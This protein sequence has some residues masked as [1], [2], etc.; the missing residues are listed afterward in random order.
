V[1]AESLLTISA[2][3]RAVDLAPSTLRYYHEAGLLPPAE[4]D[5]STGYRYYTPEL[6][7]R[8]HLIRR[9]REI[10]VSVQSMRLVLEGPADRAADVLAGVAEAARERARQTSAVVD[11]VISALRSEERAATSVAVVV[12]GSE[13]AAGLRRVSTVAATGDEPGLCGVLLDLDRTGLSVVATDRYRLAA[14]EI[15]VV[16]ALTEQ[17]RAFV[18]LGAIPELVEWLAR[19]GSLTIRLGAGQ[20]SLIDE[21]TCRPVETAP[22]RFPAYRLIL[23]SLPTPMGRATFSRDRVMEIL[24]S[25]DEAP[26]RLSVGNDRVTISREGEPEGVHLNAVTS[27]DRFT[28]S[29]SPQLFHGALEC[30]V[31]TEVSVRYVEP[32]QP[33]QLVS[34][35]QRRL[36]LLLM[37]MR[38]E[39]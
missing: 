23:D 8:A 30:M 3:A 36:G 34:V 14:W 12:D 2:F 11:E 26:A 13:L 7:R 25:M 20:A 39:S 37:P 38:A 24:A 17:R 9:M 10:G 6:A 15:P 21:I 18:P 35:E 29:L 4:I 5:A 31:G 28:V 32:N 27:G 33:V 19:R 22:D 16:E 1:P